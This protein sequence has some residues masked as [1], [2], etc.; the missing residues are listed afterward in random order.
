M[1]YKNFYPCS[2]DNC[3]KQIK[4]RG[5]CSMH[6]KRLKKHRDLTKVLPRGNFSKNPNCTIGKCRKKH[7]ARG[8]C[9]MHYRRWKIYGN[10][11]IVNSTQ[12]RTTDDG[13]IALQIPNHPLANKKGSVYEHRLVMS[14]H[15]GRLLLPY[16]SVHHK[17][18]NRKDNRIKNLELWSKAQPAGQ[19]VEDKVKYAIE[20]LEQY[21]PE[22]LSTEKA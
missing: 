11:Q 10:P 22:L 9:Q 5:L 4:A 6:Y 17:N 16:E 20:I 8:M 19:R 3:K 13:Y 21:A 14:E 12:Y 1:P 15:I 18:G 2:V 7:T